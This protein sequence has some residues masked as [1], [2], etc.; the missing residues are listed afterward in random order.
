MKITFLHNFT[1]TLMYISKTRKIS[2]NGAFFLSNLKQAFEFFIKIDQVQNFCSSN[3]RFQYILEKN[4]FR[5]F[6][7]EVVICFMY[8][9]NISTKIS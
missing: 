1:S 6:N 9:V 4:P 8:F 3:Q 7:E 2:A 5:T